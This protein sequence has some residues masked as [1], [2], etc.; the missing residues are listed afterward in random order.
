MRI[1]KLQL[2]IPPDVMA[3]LKTGDKILLS[4]TLYT[5]RDVAHARL[6]ELIR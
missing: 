5:A 4:G 2:P 1:L 3:S 6:C